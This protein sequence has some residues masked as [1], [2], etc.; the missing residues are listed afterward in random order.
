[1]HINYLNVQFNDDMADKIF[2][3]DIDIGMMRHKLIMILQ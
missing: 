3:D 1:M 2:C